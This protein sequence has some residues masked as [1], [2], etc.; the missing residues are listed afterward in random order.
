VVKET[1]EGF[2]VFL[3][4]V[5]RNIV[6]SYLD[7]T[8]I[9]GLE[10]VMFEPTLSSSGRLFMVDGQSDVASIIIDFGSESSDISI[11]D[12]HVLVAGTVQGG[13]ESF[14]A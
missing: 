6:D 7:L 3:V 14:T 8:Q 12:K 4:A 5:P 9:L 1:A 10:T 11:F 13:G 2:D